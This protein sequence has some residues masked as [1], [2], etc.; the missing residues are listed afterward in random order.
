MATESR[1]ALLALALALAGCPSVSRCRDAT[2]LLTV[3][4]DAAAAAADTLQ[5]DIAVDGNTRR[6]A[7]SHAR[8]S[9]GGT[10]EV[11]FPSGYPAGK[12]VMITVT[13][14]QGGSPL[15]AGTTTVV[16]PAGCAT[17]ALA[18]AGGATVADLA[19][20]SGD[21]A[22]GS[23]DL[24]S[25]DMCPST[26]EN[27]FNGIDDNCDGLVDCA[28]PQCTGGTAPIAEC[29]ADPGSAMAGTLSTTSCPAA[30]PTA[31]TL[32]AG[33]NPGSC[34]GGSCAC[35]NGLNGPAT[36]S[37]SLDQQGGTLVSCTVVGTN[38]FSKTNADGCVAFAAMSS[39]TYYTLS[40][41]TFNATC[42]P[43]TGGTPVKNPPTWTTTDKFCGGGAVGA[44]CTAGKVCM[45]KA[46]NHCVLQTGNQVACSVPGY[47]VANSTPFN[48]GFDD[49]GRSCACSCAL[50]GSCGNVVGFGNGLCSSLFA[51]A[52]GCQKNL[53][54]DHAQISGPSGVACAP[55]ATSS[56]STS[57]A[58]FERTVC[59]TN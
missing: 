56:G 1:T 53:S 59:C 55:A 5:L 18:V 21:L 42:N 48:T 6:T 37:A 33:L 4:F 46:A 22:S 44:G 40:T 34:A 58:G 9:S 10:I 45:P 17:A 2:L 41:P 19:G 15:G 24:A 36:C 52:P 54:Y 3:S 20:A 43:P 25:S 28:D 12:S 30:Y 38:V 39:T 8:G 13:A 11:R 16:P 14:L 50:S 31:T 29:V 27:C 57:T 23:G 26:V 32:F 35:G 47:A 49:S 51:V 7:L